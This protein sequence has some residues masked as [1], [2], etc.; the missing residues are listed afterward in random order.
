MDERYGI[1]RR[2]A[3]WGENSYLDRMKKMPLLLMLI[4]AFSFVAPA[5]EKESF[6]VFNGDWQP[7]KIDSAVYILRIHWISDTCWQWDYYNFTGPLLRTEQFRDHDGKV[8]HGASHYY[9]EQGW[10]DSAGT[11]RKGKK[12]GDFWKLK[13]DTFDFTTKYVYRDDLLLETIDL[14]KEKDDTTSYPDERESEFPGKAGAWMRYL[15]KTVKYPDRAV[16]GSIQ[17]EVRVAFIVNKEGVIEDPYI[18]RSIEYSLD[19]EALRVI[20]KSGKWVPGFQDGKVV[21]TY[22]IQPIVFRLQ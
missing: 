8:R 22:K 5:Q 7:T 18:A 20:R 17:G 13:K 2:L 16:N 4:L 9:N 14:T 6:F 10:L 21:R 19:E 15:N 11:Y 1:W 12:N 3:V